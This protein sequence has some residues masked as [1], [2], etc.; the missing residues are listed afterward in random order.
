MN[1]GIYLGHSPLHACTVALVLNTRT[2]LTSPHFHVIIDDHFD[3]VTNVKENG[4]WMTKCGYRSQAFKDLQSLD[5]ENQTQTG[6]TEN[7]SLTTP[8]E[9]QQVNLQH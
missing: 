8:P 4:I 9:T 5:E 2:G 6:N 7:N 3:T 1:P